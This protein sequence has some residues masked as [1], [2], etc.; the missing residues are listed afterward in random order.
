MVKKIKVKED[1]T[2]KEFGFLK[3]IRRDGDHY[4][5]S[6]NKYPKWLC[7]CECGKIVSVFQSSLKAG[8]QK[9]CGCKHFTA[10][11]KFNEYSICGNIVEVKM[12]NCNE[13]MV[14]D[15]EDWNRLK[16]FCWSKGNTGYAEARVN[17]K[18]TPF[19]HLVIDCERGMVR[20][21]KNRNKLDNRKENLRVVTYSENNSNRNYKNET[22][23][24][25]ISKNGSGFSAK[26]FINGES[27]YLGTYRTIEEAVRV[28]KEVMN[29]HE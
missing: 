1:L 20:D 2:D 19:H 12:T 7:Q 22:G 26:I 25:G 14:C 28:R 5:K 21:H 27:K 11:K 4:T 16:V 17:G 15:L 8:Q 29:N 23:H 3:V 9:S 24:R 13:I 10:C 6:G 18:T